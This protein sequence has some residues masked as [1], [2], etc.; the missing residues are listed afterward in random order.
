MSRWWAGWHSEAEQTYGEARRASIQREMLR[1]EEDE[2]R[3]VM[4]VRRLGNKIVISIKSKNY[5]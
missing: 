2:K 3:F 1:E 4:L 5:I